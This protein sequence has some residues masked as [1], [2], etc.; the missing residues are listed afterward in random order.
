MT[1][2]FLVL[3]ALTAVLVACGGSSQEARDPSTGGDEGQSSEPHER[4]DT[5]MGV[6]GEQGALDLNAVNAIFSKSASKLRSCFDKGRRR[7]PYLGGETRFKVLV[8]AAGAAKA[9]Y[10]TESTLGD[11]E[12]EA[13][14]LDVLRAASWPKPEGGKEGY[15]ESGLVFDPSDEEREP[16]AWAP[17]Q[18]GD[19]YASAKDAV[20]KCKDDAGTGSV[21]ATLYVDVDGKAK[22]VGLSFADEKGEQAASCIVSALRAVK[23]PSP[24][25]YAA[26]ASVVF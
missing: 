8:D 14:M 5:G 22:A 23:F 24:G 17:E 19:G 26:K 15:A 10:M 2:R 9:A 21:K 6:E 25:S 11:R 1:A 16:I 4:P 18:L 7:L 12:T 20:A 13:C 3:T